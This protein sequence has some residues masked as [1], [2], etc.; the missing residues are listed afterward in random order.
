MKKISFKLLVYTLILLF[1][2]LG[3][4][5]FLQSNIITSGFKSNLKNKM[6]Q[7]AK[8]ISERFKNNVDYSSEANNIANIINGRVSIYDSNGGLIESYG[9]FM[10]GRTRNIERQI[11]LDVLSGKIIYQTDQRT[12]QGSTLITL[13]MPIINNNKII[14]AVFIHLPLHDIQN[15]V[16]KIKNQIFILFIIALLLSFIGAYVLSSVFTKPILKINEA[17]KAIA[18]GNYDVKIDIKNNDE[19]GELAKT[20]NHMA[21][22]L[23]TTEKLRRD[24]I[25]NITHELRTPL[26]IIKSYAEAIYD[27]ILDKEG[28]KEYSYSIMEESE[29]LSKLINEILELSK[30]QSGVIQLKIQTIDLKELFGEI[31]NEVNIIKGNRK[32]WSFTE[33]VSIKGDRELLKRAFSNIVI[34]AINHT[35]GSGNIYIRANKEGALV[36]I[37]IKDDGEGIDEA[38]LPYIFNRF[39]STNTKKGVGGLGLSIAKEIILMHHGEI[40]VYSKKGEGAEFVI[41]LRANFE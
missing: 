33:N 17:A 41:K 10:F 8:D 2:M 37:S 23:L 11:I 34:N 7:Y 18:N 22:N 31:I 1:C 20:I 32:F 28:V 25:A 4:N 16:Q 5:F 15:D 36:K 3:L 29:H 9:R 30:L 38:D 27:D 35:N 13:G 40:E 14:A 26:S 21:Q 6:I 39:F 24:F 19:I 12:F